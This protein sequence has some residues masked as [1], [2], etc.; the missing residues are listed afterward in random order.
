MTARRFSASSRAAC[1]SDVRR[2]AVDD[3]VNIGFDGYALG[4]LSVGE[5]QE[6]MLEMAE[7]RPAAAARHCPEVHHG[8]G[9]PV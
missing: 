1:T 2:R 7:I 3:L 9:D 6:L 5:P 8:G 4:G